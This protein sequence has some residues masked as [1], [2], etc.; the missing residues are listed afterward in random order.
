MTRGPRRRI[1][2]LDRL[3]LRGLNGAKDEVLLTATDGTHTTHQ[4]V[5]WHIDSPVLLLDVGEQNWNVSDTVLLPVLGTGPAGPLTFSASGLPDGLTIDEDAGLISGT[6]TEDG[7]FVTTVTADDGTYSNTIQIHWQVQPAGDGS[8]HW[9]VP[10][11]GGDDLELDVQLTEERPGELLRWTAGVDAGFSA[12]LT[13][14]STMDERTVVDRA[15][16]AGLALHGM[17]VHGYYASRLPPD[18]PGQLVVSY[19]TPPEHT[20]PAA[21]AALIQLL[22]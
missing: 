14:P 10:G 9:R 12:A 4:A 22:A 6:L 13:L 17:S 21:V 19:A 7:S 15:A 1:F 18:R 8:L 11:P 16:A 5:R 2:K 3:R 20:Y